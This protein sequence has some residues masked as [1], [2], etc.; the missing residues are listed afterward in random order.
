[1]RIMREVEYTSRRPVERG[2]ITFS[3]PKSE[4]WGIRRVAFAVLEIAKLSE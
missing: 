1:M 4:S 3:G 2:V